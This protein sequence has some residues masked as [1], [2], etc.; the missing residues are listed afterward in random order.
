MMYMLA[1]CC[2][3]VFD[4]AIEAADLTQCAALN[5]TYQNQYAV[6]QNETSGLDYRTG[7]QWCAFKS[8]GDTITAAANRKA[9]GC[10]LEVACLPLNYCT[11]SC[12]T[13]L[14]IF[15]GHYGQCDIANTTLQVQNCL[16]CELLFSQYDE[17]QTTC[18]VQAS[19]PKAYVI[20]FQNKLGTQ[21]DYCVRQFPNVKFQFPSSQGALVS[22]N[23]NTA[24]YIGIG[25]GSLILCIIGL[26]V[27][28]RYRFLTKNP[29]VGG[30]GSRYHHYPSQ[31]LNDGQGGAKKRDMQSQNNDI[32][33]DTDMAKFRVPQR[34]IL[35]VS[36]LVKGGYGVVFRA[37][38]NGKDVAMKQLLPSKA[39]DPSATA[40]FMREIRLCARLNHPNIVGFVGIAWSTI[41]DLAVLSEFMPNGDL[42]DLIK[43]ERNKPEHERIFNWKF[44]TRAIPTTKTIAAGDVAKALLYLHSFQPPIIH[45][46]LKSKNVLMSDKWEAK[47]SDF[48]ISRVTN[49]DETM[50]SNIGTMAWIAPEVL[51]GGKYSEKAD[52]YSFGVFLS[53]LD[54]LETPYSNM[55]TGDSEEGFS[56]AR[57]A[58]LVSQGQLQPS[59]TNTIPSKILTLAKQCL[60]FRDEERPTADIVASTL[61]EIFHEL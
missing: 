43:S 38:Y 34:N 55:N 2:I 57:I 44:Q 29:H 56:N 52:I 61:G 54:M 39:K 16:E 21:L 25:V 8:C 7:R 49:V 50:T 1:L 13:Q 42:N 26:L 14:Q 27:F 46:D 5:Q 23:N 33:F 36:M 31:E 19:F 11:N 60:S 20:D 51:T 48:G 10:T 9:A 22:T 18:Q 45:R 53:E 12:Q 47:L 41:V 35:N 4:S 32:R 58:L 3:L 40:E 6:C 24:L 37:T 17:F 30:S 15:Q 28:R 59:F